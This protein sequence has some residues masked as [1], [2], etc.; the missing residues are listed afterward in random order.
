[1]LRLRILGHPKKLESSAVLMTKLAKKPEANVKPFPVNT[2]ASYQLAADNL[3]ANLWNLLI[4][5]I[6]ADFPVDWAVGILERLKETVQYLE[7]E[8]C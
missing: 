6:D 1:M 8:E 3:E 4:D 2:L 5:E 7:D